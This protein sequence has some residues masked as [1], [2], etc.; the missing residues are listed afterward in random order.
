ME[1]GYYK[2]FMPVFIENSGDLVGCY[3]SG[4]DRRTDGQTN[5]ER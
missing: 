3:H 2:A 5:K 4:T 1:L